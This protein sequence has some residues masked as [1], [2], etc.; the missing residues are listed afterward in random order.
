MNSEYTFKMT[1][2]ESLPHCKAGS[3]IVVIVWY[4]DLQLPMQSVSFT[5][6]FVSS[7]PVQTRCT[8][9]TLC[10]KVCQLLAA[11]W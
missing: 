7:N 6:N 4:L 1:T 5:T 8:H 10:D 11:V 3:V 9:T 2:N